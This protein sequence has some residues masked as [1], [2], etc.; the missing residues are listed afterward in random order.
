MRL[1]S[2]TSDLAADLVMST[3]PT[4]LQAQLRTLLRVARF[5]DFKL[6]A[7]TIEELL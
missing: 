2:A 6:L 4:S 5:H 3:P 1:C 7:G